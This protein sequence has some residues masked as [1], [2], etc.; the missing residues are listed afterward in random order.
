M[1]AGTA[2]AI[3]YEAVTDEDGA[4]EPAIT[5]LVDAML[6]RLSELARD[7]HKFRAKRDRKLQRATF[8]DIL[9]YFEVCVVSIF[10]RFF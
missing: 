6:P 9:K 5:A 1:A 3:A 10:L 2:L 4:T 7:S 8:R